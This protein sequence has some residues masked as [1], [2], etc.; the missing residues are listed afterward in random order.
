MPVPY[1]EAFGEMEFE[2]TTYEFDNANPGD[3]DGGDR[4]H[5]LLQYSDKGW[6]KVTLE[7]S[8]ELPA[9]TK[10][11]FPQEERSDPPGKVTVAIDCPDT[12]YRYGETVQ[13]SEIEE[14]TYKFEETIE[15]KYAYGEVKLRPVLVRTEKNDDIADPTYAKYAYMRIA[16][17]STNTI[18]F[19]DVET[20]GSSL[21]DVRFESFEKNDAIPDD[22]LYHLDRSDYSSPRVRVN[23]DYELITR[24]LD[25]DHHTGWAA[26]FQ[27]ALAPWIAK[28]VV[29]ELVLWALASA[30]EE[31]FDADWQRALVDEYAPRLYEYTDAEEPEELSEKLL[32][33]G[34]DAHYIMNAV[35]K[36]VQDQVRIT[37]PIEDFTEKQAT[38]YFLQG[39]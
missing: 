9:G 7:G 31:E 10:K 4:V 27:G 28:D 22:N 5:S 11:L 24:V 29:V 21:M 23:E 15:R 33:G 36:V 20:E 3:F 34:D 2:L 32:Q 37:K 19:D 17:G 35:E 30:G 18:L 13:T 38:D 39:K 8:I 14:G 16:D 26:D 12:H 6:K 25:H 1:R